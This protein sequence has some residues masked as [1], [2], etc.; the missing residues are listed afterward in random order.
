MIRSVIELSGLTIT[1]M[2]PGIEWPSSHRFEMNKK[3]I[4]SSFLFWWNTLL[5][6]ARCAFKRP[7]SCE[8]HQGP[9]GILQQSPRSSWMCLSKVIADEHAAHSQKLVRN[10]KKLTERSKNG[11]TNPCA[12]LA[13][14]RCIDL[15]FHVLDG[16]I[17]DLLEQ[18]ITESYSLHRWASSTSKSIPKTRIITSKQCRTT[19]QHNVTIE[20]TTKIHVC[21]LDG[22]HH[23]LVHWRLFRANDIRTEQDFWSLEAFMVELNEINDEP[24]ECHSTS[25]SS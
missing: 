10:K 13:F 3:S 6:Q 5:F 2:L 4:S 25:L 16:S 21:L 20:R 14:R 19:R 7:S 17:P 1:F 15:D 9:P 8:S 12:V 23:H 22:I 11:S 24:F 18:T